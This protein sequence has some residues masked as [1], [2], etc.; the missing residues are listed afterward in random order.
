[1]RMLKVAREDYVPAARR[2]AGYLGETSAW[3][4]RVVLEPRTF[5]QNAG[6]PRIE[7][8]EN[9]CSISV[10][11]TAIPL[12]GSRIWPKACGPPWKAG[13]EAGGPKERAG[14]ADQPPTSTTL[15][16]HRRACRGAQAAWGPM[17]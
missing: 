16:A 1:M 15:C 11:G 17:M 2:E 13:T 14:N 4:G 6:R 12:R 8:D 5:G 9:W 10:V 7:N 3:R